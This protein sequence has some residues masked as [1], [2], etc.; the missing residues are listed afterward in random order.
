MR[1]LLRPLYGLFLATVVLSCSK[2]KDPQP[3][4]P[5]SA[6][7]QGDVFYSDTD[8]D[9][10]WL[11]DPEGAATIK[12]I[13]DNSNKVVED[14]LLD[15]K[16]NKIYLAN[17]TDGKIYVADF[18]GSSTINPADYLSVSFPRS[19]ALW[20][21]DGKKT[22]YAVGGVLG[23]IREIDVATKENKLVD[24]GQGNGFVRAIAVDNA[25]GTIYINQDDLGIKKISTEPA[26]ISTIVQA[27]LDNGKIDVDPAGKTLY[28]KGK[29]IL[30]STIQKSDLSGNNISKVTF[31]GNTFSSAVS[32][33]PIKKTL[34]CSDP[35]ELAGGL[36]RI[37]LTDLTEK[38]FNTTIVRAVAVVK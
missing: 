14:I 35:D 11:H 38:K 22:L 36:K 7:T 4:Q 9:I 18:D 24:L 25:N 12:K 30:N 34:F 2:S 26:N 10:Y 21:R 6:F 17:Y 27:D 33:D 15:Q 31:G 32:V 29:G 37:K 28:W 23:F 1:K 13:H 5:K 3:Q 19:L 20:E 8:G 16:A